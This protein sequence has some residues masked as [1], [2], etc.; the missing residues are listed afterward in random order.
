MDVP[1]AHDNIFYVEQSSVWSL[2]NATSCQFP[3]PWYDEHVLFGFKFQDF[4]SPQWLTNL[5]PYLAFWPVQQ[6]FDGLLFGRLDISRSTLKIC[7]YN[8]ETYHLDPDMI[9]SWDRLE[10]VLLNLAKF[11]LSRKSTTSSVLGLLLLPQ[12]CGYPQSLASA[13]YHLSHQL[14]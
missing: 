13:C 11:L 12:N 9:E 6:T 14:T 5:Y 2:P 8:M 3:I 7:M 4:C 10:F 1:A